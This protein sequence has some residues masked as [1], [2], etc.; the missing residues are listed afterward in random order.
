MKQAPLIFI[1]ILFVGLGEMAVS[2]ARD[3]TAVIGLIP[4]H[5]QIG[6]D[7]R[8]RGGFVE[9]VKAIDKVYQDGQITIKILPIA[10]AIRNVVNGQ[11][12]FFIPYIPNPHVPLATLPFS[13][14]AEPIVDVSFVLYSLADKP[15]PRVDALEKF[16]IETLRGAALHFPFKISEID[17]FKQ[18]ILRVV[19]GRSDGFIV[20]QDAGDKFIRDNKIKQIHRTLYATWD[21]SIMIPKG[22]KGEMIDRIVSEALQELKKSGKLTPITETIH[23]PYTDWQP[24]QMGW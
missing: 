9:V 12:D 7:G 21:S 1:L 11:A 5:A 6:E 16:N 8:P 10:R 4:P 13:F 23:R 18:G 24:Y 17:S 2:E 3:L 22:P 20:E 19:M 14:A 15:V